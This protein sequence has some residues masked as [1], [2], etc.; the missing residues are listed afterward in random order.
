MVFRNKLRG[1]RPGNVQ[2]DDVSNPNPSNATHPLDRFKQTP[3]P[4][5]DSFIK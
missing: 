5:V 1:E 3:V 4:R 2:K